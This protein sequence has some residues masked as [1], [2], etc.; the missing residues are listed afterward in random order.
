MSIEKQKRLA[1]AYQFEMQAAK[2][3]FSIVGK[4]GGYAFT[5]RDKGKGKHLSACVLSCTFDFYEFRL[6]KGKRTP[7]LLIVQ[8]HD[9]LAPV[10]V[11]CLSTGRLYDPAVGALTERENR[12]RRNQAEVKQLISGV[13]IG[14]RGALAAL[15][16][17]PARTRQYYQA[18]CNDLL[19]G[20]VGRPWATV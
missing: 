17:M 3:G 7:D 19:R 11:L 14:D 4:R 8:E 9:A 10:R 18:K 5:V 16:D 2:L 6:A 13:L 12:Q 15:K 1:V 20:R